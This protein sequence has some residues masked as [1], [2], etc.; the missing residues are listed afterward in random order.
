[1]TKR[2]GR[3]S[4]ALPRGGLHLR[5]PRARN[6]QASSPSASSFGKRSRRLRPADRLTAGPG[7]GGFVETAYRVGI[8]VDGKHHAITRNWRLEKQAVC[9]AG[10]IILKVPGSFDTTDLIACRRCVEHLARAMRDTP[11]DTA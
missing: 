1:M 10:R 8:A 9:G 4:W 2:P 6:D 7:A 11:H 5:A 3:G